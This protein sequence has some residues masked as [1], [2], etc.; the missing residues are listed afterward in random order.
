MSEENWKTREPDRD[1]LE[2]HLEHELRKRGLTRRDLMKGGMAMASA[3]GLGALFAACG[4]DEGEE[5][6]ATTA[7]EAAGT[8]AQ[9]GATT[10]AEAP[11][12]TGTLRV[13]GL[14]VDLIDPIKE[15]GEA[16]LGFKLAFDVT[17]S[18]TMV[19]KAITQPGSFDIFSGYV[20]QYNQ[21][22]PS[23]NFHNEEIARLG[24][25]PQMNKLM[26]YGYVDPT[27]GKGQGCTY[28]DGDAPFRSLYVD[29][30]QSGQWPTSQDTPS[31]LDGILVSW[32]D[33]TNGQ[34]IGSEP[35]Y[36]IGAPGAIFNMD[37]MGYNA[38][39]IQKEPEDVSWAELLNAE[40]KG[41]VALLNDPGIGMQDAGLAAK[42]LGLLQFGN[43][44][45]MTK[46]EIDALV[47]VLIDMKDQFRAFWTTFDESVNLMASG[48]VV[49]ESMWSPAVA[50]L[51]AQGQNIRYAAPP[52]GFRGWCGNLSI[53]KEA[54]SDPSLLQACYDYI[55]W[56]YSGEPAALM[57]RQG[58]YNSVQET[59]RE[60]VSPA[61]WDFW[62][63]GQ[64]ASEDLP[65]ITGQVGDIKQGQ[66]RDGGAFTTRA[67]KYATWNSYFQE[68]EYQVQRWNE[69]LSA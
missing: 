6:A 34:P 58:Y 40:Y 62:I 12:F 31:E 20:Y 46:E 49:I 52:E 68:N 28:G 18:V 7:A 1:Q 41:R 50:L 4:G 35:L 45:N 59:S 32:I 53:S 17:D 42:A 69:F 22:W 23:G 29:P 38:D 60:F 54:E 55:N 61:E 5:G 36:N 39:V 51:V 19:Q 67:C 21:A 16:A 33:E 27:S 44:G 2:Q 10:A 30:D 26:N 3:L 65:G 43:I 15:M 47:S 63:E 11:A 37:S 13:T 24:F 57:M 25:W 14:G 64:P 9:E 56:W 48:E 66:V 8:T